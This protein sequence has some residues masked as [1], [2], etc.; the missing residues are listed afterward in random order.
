MAEELKNLRDMAFDKVEKLCTRLK[1]AVDARNERLVA[2]GQQE[3]AEQFGTFEQLHVQYATR[4]KMSLTSENMKEVYDGLAA[5]VL[6]TD[7]AA[8]TFQ[9]DLTA[10]R[11]AEAAQR[12]EIHQR[13]SDMRKRRVMLSD[14][15]REVE[16]LIGHMAD[17]VS[18]MGPDSEEPWRPEPAVVVGEV[19]HCEKRFEVAKQ[20]IEQAATMEQN[21]EAEEAVKET[22]RQAEKKF[23][24]ILVQLKSAGWNKGSASETSS[25]NSSQHQRQRATNSRTR[26]STIRGFQEMFASTYHSSGTSMKS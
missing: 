15:T 25:R 1:S 3:L 18:K 19:L 16:M 12:N 10:A 11:E 21:E 24:Q 20:L 26:R 2:K 13:D 5:L 23:R 4:A 14:F 9:Q 8:W 7:E 17:L 22:G 6:E